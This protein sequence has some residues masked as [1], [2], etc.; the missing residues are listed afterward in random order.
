[1]ECGQ[2]KI[3]LRHLRALGV[4]LEEAL[5]D[6]VLNLGHRAQAITVRIGVL[7]AFLTYGGK[8]QEGY[9]GSGDR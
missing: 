1:M 9:G 8:A 3:Y 5:H 4:G 6:E 7:E 2:I